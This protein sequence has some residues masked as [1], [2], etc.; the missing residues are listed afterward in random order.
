MHP[1]KTLAMKIHC[2]EVSRFGC[3]RKL[4]RSELRAGMAQHCTSDGRP[5][6]TSSCSAL[7]KKLPRGGHV[8]GHSGHKWNDLV[9][10]LAT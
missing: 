4:S 8:K 10:E 6:S 5:E 3:V 7:A 2:H 1:K 9:D